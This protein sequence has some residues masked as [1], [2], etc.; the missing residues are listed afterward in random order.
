MTRHAL[1]TALLATLLLTGCDDPKKGK[2]SDAKS[3]APS[4]KP[5]TTAADVSKPKTMPELLVDP[6]LR[7]QSGEGFSSFVARHQRTF[8]EL[9]EVLR[10]EQGLV[11]R[12]EAAPDRV[13]LPLVAGKIEE[14]GSVAPC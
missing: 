3:A 4:A 2:P 10:I 5:V 8:D 12:V 13:D 1:A 6:E 9:G 7:R 11:Q 14:R